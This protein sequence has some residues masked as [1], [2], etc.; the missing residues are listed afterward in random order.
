MSTENPEDEVYRCSECNAIVKL[1]DTECPVCG[2][3]LGETVEEDK[4][5]IVLLKIFQNDFEAQTAKAQLEQE[6]IICLLSGDNEGG[7]AP[8][9]S[10][11]RGIR[12]LVNEN[13]LE[14]AIEVLK[15]MEMY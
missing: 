13:N 5:D 4:G 2:A 15:A 8:N 14:R 7:M 11:T 12:I 1:E 3:Y 10:L 9:L 6:G